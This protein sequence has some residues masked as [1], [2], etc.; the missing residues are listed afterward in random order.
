VLIVDYKSD[1]LGGA[2]PAAIAG[3]AYRT[4]R[5]VYALAALRAG[6][7]AVEVAHC[8]LER[9]DE[10]VTVTFVASDVDML[11][12]DL[13]RLAEGVVKGR[14]EVAPTPHR[15]LCG[16]CPAEGGLC[17]WPLALTRRESPDRLF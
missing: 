13:D 6:A 16:G 14:F 12:R 3:G 7:T 11:E 1:R 9:A 5:L 10:P 4:Q 8:F 17:S 15:G 2:D